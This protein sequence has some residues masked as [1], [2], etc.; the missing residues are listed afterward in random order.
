MNESLRVVIADDERP[1]RSFLAAMLRG[2]EDVTLVGEAEDGAEAIEV[3]E[4]TRPDLALL[5]LQMPEVDGLGV[6]RLLKKSCLPLV[7]FVTAYDGYAVP[8]FELNAVDYLL[9]PVEHSRL[10][11][12]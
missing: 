5:D 6:I 11:E 9:K 10:R 1:A 2:F 4:R 8:A 12:T 3:I 7:A